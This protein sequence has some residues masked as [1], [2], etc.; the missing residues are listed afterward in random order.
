MICG[1][2]TSA[3]CCCQSCPTRNRAL[4]VG[5]YAGAVPPYSKEEPPNVPAGRRNAPRYTRSVCC[6]SGRLPG[7]GGGGVP[8]VGA[9]RGKVFAAVIFD[10]A[11]TFPAASTAATVKA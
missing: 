11:D 5:L 2:V 8:G 6:T 3:T 7:A 4:L 1:I 10:G 9:G